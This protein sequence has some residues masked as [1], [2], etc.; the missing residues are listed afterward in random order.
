MLAMGWLIVG[1][2]LKISFFKAAALDLAGQVSGDYQ[3]RLGHGRSVVDKAAEL[4]PAKVIDPHDEA[5]KWF[6]E[7]R[8]IS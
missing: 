4:S 2:A 6:E 5:R 7:E 3:A 8:A 1:V